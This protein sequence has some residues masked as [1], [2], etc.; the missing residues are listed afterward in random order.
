MPYYSFPGVR[1]VPKA[2]FSFWERLQLECHEED[3]STYLEN[4]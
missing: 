3:E 4:V 2:L 1:T